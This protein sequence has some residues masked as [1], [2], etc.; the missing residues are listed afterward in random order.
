V[1]REAGRVI[2]D[3]YEL[4]TNAYER[5]LLVR[6]LY[7]KEVALF[8]GNAGVKSTGKTE[9]LPN[10]SEDEKNKVKKGLAGILDGADVERKKRILTAVAEN[11]D[12]V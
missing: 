5:S 4:Y 11:I 6:D 3:A 7:G 2:A 1:H 12:V 9:K 8:E 10:V